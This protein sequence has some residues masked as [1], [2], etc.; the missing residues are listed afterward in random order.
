MKIDLLFGEPLYI[1]SI[2]DLRK[3]GEPVKMR[4]RH[5]L[6]PS[7]ENV[8]HVK[9]WSKRSNEGVEKYLLDIPDLCN[10]KDVI[11]VGDDR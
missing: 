5:R 11:Y 3:I 2:A 4:I 8:R 1:K 9:P 6:L 7:L 10:A